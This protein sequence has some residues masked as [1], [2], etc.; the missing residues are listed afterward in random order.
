MRHY[1]D[2]CV[3]LSASSKQ[4]IE[5]G[6]EESRCDGWVGHR[7]NAREHL[8]QRVDPSLLHLLRSCT[9][10][11]ISFLASVPTVTQVFRARA[12][13]HTLPWW[14]LRNRVQLVLLGGSSSLLIITRTVAVPTFSLKANAR[15]LCKLHR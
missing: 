2:Y 10:E 1:V 12:G 5:Q 11:E 9:I 15:F 3:D 6:K 7:L 14:P 13:I 8:G 4:R